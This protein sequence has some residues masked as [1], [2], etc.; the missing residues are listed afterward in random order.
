MT[1]DEHLLV[2]DIFHDGPASEAG[3]WAG[4]VRNI[5]DERDAALA[6]LNAAKAVADDL[7]GG[8]FGPTVAAV[9]RRLQ[10]ILDGA[11]ATELRVADTT[12]VREDVLVAICDQLLAEVRRDMSG[13]DRMSVTNDGPRWEVAVAL[14]R[15]SAS[16]RVDRIEPATTETT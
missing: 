10:R 4:E 8:S 2:A 11:D 1:D 14:T 16:A 5:I 9:G 13:R 3:R 15:W 7:Q 12:A 6:K